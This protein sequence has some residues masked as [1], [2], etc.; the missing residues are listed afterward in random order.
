MIQLLSCGPS[1]TVTSWQ[2][3]HI[4]VYTFYTNAKD[5]KNVAYQNSGVQ[6]EAADANGHAVSYYGYID[7]IWELSYG[8]NLRIPMFKC[9]WI[10]LLDVDNYGL[11]LVDLGNMGYKDDPWVLGER[12]VQVFYITD[13]KKRKKHIVISGKQR[14]LGVD[15]ITDVEEYNRYEELELFKD[16]EQKIKVVENNLDKKLKPW[17]RI[18]CLGRTING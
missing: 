9:Q 18:D 4:N 14:I 15:G 17:Y 1:S 16:F 13:L 2:A 12:V 8:G 3:Y 10:K 11:T 7:A 5:K 6:I